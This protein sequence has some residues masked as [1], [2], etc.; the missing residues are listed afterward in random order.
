MPRARADSTYV[1]AGD[2]RGLVHAAALVL[3]LLGA[4]SLATPDDAAAATTTPAIIV[5]QAPPPTSTARHATIRWSAVPAAHVRCRLDQQPQRDCQSP[6]RA[7]NLAIGR[8]TLRI[9]AT[10]PD[11]RSVRTVSWRVSAARGRTGGPP[12][13]STGSAHLDSGTIARLVATVDPAGLATRA[14]FEFGRTAA[15]G[16]VTPNR[17]LGSGTTPRTLADAITALRAGATYYYRV[18]AVNASGTTVG[19]TRSVFVPALVPLGVPPVTSDTSAT[20]PGPPAVGVPLPPPT[21]STALAPSVQT[22]SASGDA[23]GWAVQGAVDPRGGST[24]VFAEYGTS[25]AYESQSAVSTI[26]AGAGAHVVV[27]P[28]G[29]LQS[30]TTYHYRVVAENPSGTTYGADATFTTAAPLAAYVST[31]GDDAGDGSLAHPWRTLQ[32]AANTAPAGTTVY[33]RAGTYTG[34][35]MTRS[36]TPGAPITF[37]GYPGETAVL[38]PASGTN[39]VDI[40]GAH[41]VVLDDLTIQGATGQYN[42]GVM[43]RNGASDITVT[44]STL[45]DNHSYGVRA[46]N[47]TNVTITGNLITA[48]DTGVRIDFSGAGTVVAGN[49]IVDNQGM[50]VDD[51]TPGNDTGANAIVF[52]KSTGAISVTG[53]TIHGNRAPSDDYGYDGGAFEIFGASNVT[54]ADNLLYDNQ[55][56]VETGTDPSHTPCANNVFVHNVAYGGNDKSLVSAYGPVA[57]G[58]LLRCAQNMLIAQNTF[59]DLDFWTYDIS[60]S[61]SYSGSVDGLQI[62]DNVNLQHTDKVYALEFALPASVVI[63][64]N[65]DFSESGGPLGSVAGHGTTSSLADLRAWAGIDTHGVDADPQ[66]VD[67][68]AHD[69]RLRAGSPAIG[70]GIPIA[71]VT[72]G[73]APAAGRY[74]AP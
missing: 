4:A 32:K 26:A 52:Y 10:G 23:S 73:A 12:S 65:V 39:T 3:A 59:S 43:I 24:S 44:D 67:E 15:L 30:G 13:A 58:L 5:G 68:A 8:H 27:L 36:G 66:V 35:T 6:F 54:M 9:A 47:D 61:S 31:S 37:A 49:Q 33:V 41:D 16:H 71:G 70:I 48:N 57:N 62:V 50:V 29:G 72:D 17:A 28:L 69:F 38:G 64:A 55:N 25:T 34:F 7:D 46:Y 53:N 20:V 19:T 56:V 60:Q 63:D 22:G 74:D 11:A 42:A 51:P 21:T 2:T 45:Q 40:N 18:V 1:Q 14:R